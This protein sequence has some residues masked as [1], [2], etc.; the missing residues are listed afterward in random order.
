MSA[1]ITTWC[2]ILNSLSFPCNV[3][4]SRCA[5]YCVVT[6]RR[7][8]LTAD[9]VMTTT[10]KPPCSSSFF[11]LSS[12]H[13]YARRWSL[14][15]ILGVLLNQCCHQ[16]VRCAAAAADDDDA[17][18][19]DNR[20]MKGKIVIVVSIYWC[21]LQHRESIEIIS[22]TSALYIASCHVTGQHE[23]VLQFSSVFCCHSFQMYL[24]RC[25]YIF[26]HISFPVFWSPSSAVQCFFP[27]CL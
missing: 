1:V 12:S 20:L 22:R 2:S 21:T 6:S 26:L 9:S 5:C 14:I 10:N 7:W 23:N 8:L 18:H 19:D 27:A 4:A 25:P 15:A 11:S 17:D 24:N 3:D 13:Y 16:L